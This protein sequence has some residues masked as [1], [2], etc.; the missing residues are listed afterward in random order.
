MADKTSRLLTD[1]RDAV[2]ARAMLDDLGG[3]GDT[4]VVERP[5]RTGVAV[6]PQMLQLLR[7]VLES[8]AEGQSLTIT[9]I[10]EELTTSH[11]ANMLGIS[12]P[13]LMKLVRDGEL[14]AHKVGTHT[15]LKSADVLAF[16][17]EQQA[18]RRKAF[19]ELRDLL[20]GLD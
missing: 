7:R 8:V 15:R 9:S 17:R 10:P 12:R 16:R 5:D 18:A 20:D 13:T 6:P 1:D 11:A 19:E 2:L 14:P 3:Q 4:L